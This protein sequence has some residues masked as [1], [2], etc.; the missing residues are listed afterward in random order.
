[1]ST[2]REPEKLVE[3]I[4]LIARARREPM[5]AAH[6]HRLP[7][8]DLEDCHSQATLDLL[9]TAKRGAAF[10][11][12]A[13]IANALEQRLLSRIRDRRRALCGRSPIEA[14]LASALPLAHSEGGGVEILDPRADVERLV[15]S[16]QELE[17]IARQL[18]RLSHDQRLVLAQQLWHE[19]DRERFCS[20]HNWSAEK[21]RKVAQRARARLK[22][23]V[24]CPVAGCSSD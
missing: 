20:E 8:A 17:L 2:R 13:H 14:A 4:A 9:A 18:P 22:E 24:A 15:A 3:A 23:L 6:R 16:R 12:H 1:V 7:H 21:Y 11:S 19:R 5:L 10:S